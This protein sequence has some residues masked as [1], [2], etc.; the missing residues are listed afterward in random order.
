[1]IDQFVN[2]SRNK[3]KSLI[4][5]FFIMWWGCILFVHT[6]SFLIHHRAHLTHQKNSSIGASSLWNCGIFWYKLFPMYFLFSVFN[7]DPQL[8]Y[9]F[10]ISYC[11]IIITIIF[12]CY[13]ISLS[14][15]RVLSIV[16]LYV[17]PCFGKSIY[18]NLYHIRS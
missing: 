17:F 7:L 9:Q 13:K 11:I 14:L 1:M 4:E 10:N 18:R 2:C 3:C 16:I 6:Y 8:D 15:Y 12:F 5:F